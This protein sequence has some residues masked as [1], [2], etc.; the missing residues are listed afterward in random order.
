LVIIQSHGAFNYTVRFSIHKKNQS[1]II[2][3]DPMAMHV[4]FRFNSVFDIKN[5][6][7]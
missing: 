3:D 1:L 4:P 2:R 5:V 7:I 6:H